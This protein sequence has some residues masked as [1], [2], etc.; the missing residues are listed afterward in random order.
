M[1]SSPAQTGKLIKALVGDRPDRPSQK[2]ILREVNTEF[3]GSARAAGDTLP[4]KLNILKESLRNLRRHDA[5][6]Q[7]RRRSASVVDQFNDWLADPA[8]TSEQVI[9]NISG[10]RSKDIAAA[11]RLP[12]TPSTLIKV[13]AIRSPTLVSGVQ[14]RTPG[15]SA[16]RLARS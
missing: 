14:E 10:R 3:G 8:K 1:S 16:I 5:P 11:S 6:R 15:R 2:A 13:T 4:G 7:L 12:L 9:D